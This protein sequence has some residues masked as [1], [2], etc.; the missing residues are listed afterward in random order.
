MRDVISV[1]GGLSRVSADALLARYPDIVRVTTPNPTRGCSRSSARSERR[2]R[3][4]AHA[5]AGAI[6]NA[7][8]SSCSTRSDRERATRD[9]RSGGE[10]RAVFVRGGACRVAVASAVREYADR[11]DQASRSAAVADVPLDSCDRRACVVVIGFAHSQVKRS[12]GLPPTKHLPML[13]RI[14]RENADS[15]FLRSAARTVVTDV[16]RRRRRRVVGGRFDGAMVDAR[17]SARCAGVAF[18]ARRL[19]P[20]SSLARLLPA[21]G[22]QRSWRTA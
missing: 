5:T 3:G 8:A 16:E 21:H 7:R 20:S 22:T 10:L 2:R 11:L 18:D 13:T 14:V 12:T 4:D 15:F 17:R 9:S 1:L 6:R 19:P